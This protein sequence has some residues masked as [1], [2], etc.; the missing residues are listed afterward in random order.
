MT[1]KLTN[2]EALVLFD[3]LSRISKN[4]PEGLFEDQ[5]EQRVLWNLEA[6][7]ERQLNEPL[8]SD[9]NELL[10]TARQNVRD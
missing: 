4:E 2:D 10:S 7:L 8:S 3:F 5:S 6:E 9:Y 1:V